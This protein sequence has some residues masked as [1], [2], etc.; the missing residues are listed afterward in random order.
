MIPRLRPGDVFMACSDGLWHYFTD[1]ELGA[2]LAA[3]APREATEFLIEK[4]RNRAR[5][6]GDNLCL[7]VV[8]LESLEGSISTLSDLT[9]LPAAL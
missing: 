9:T 6:G 4:A 7:V 5:G 2:S 3:L 1:A 8:K